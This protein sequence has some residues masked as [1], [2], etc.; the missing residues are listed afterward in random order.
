MASCPTVVG[1]GLSEKIMPQAGAGAA[2][3]PGA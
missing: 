3:P 2:G 1:M